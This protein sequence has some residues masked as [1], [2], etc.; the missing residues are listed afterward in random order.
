[1]ICANCKALR[2]VANELCAKYFSTT[3]KVGLS[4]LPSAITSRTIEDVTGPKGLPVI[5]TTLSLL[6]A[7]STPKL[8]YYID[9]RH[10]QYGPIFKESVGPVPCVFISDPKAMR[11]VFTHEGKY[12]IHILPEAWTTYNV[13]HNVSRGIFFM[14]GEEWLHFRRILNP[15]LLKGDQSWIDESC[16]PAIDNLIEKIKSQ[17][18]RYPYIDMEGLLYYWSLE[19]IVSILLGPQ[20]YIAAKQKLTDRID[21]LSSTLRLVFETSSKL[22]LISTKLAAKY[23]ISRWK[24]FEKSVTSALFSVADLVELLL[25][26]YVKNGEGLLG[27]LKAKMTTNEL[28]RIVTDLILAA[29]DTTAYSME[30]TLYLVGKNLEVQE[31][32]RKEVLEVKGKDD[33]G[34]KIYLKNAIKESLRL[35]PVAPFLTRILPDQAEICGYQMP[36]GTVLILSIFTA[37]RD[38]RNF[39]DPLHFDPDR[40]NRNDNNSNRMRLASIP[41]AIGARS[42]IGKKIAET[43]LQK[44]LAEIL[45]YFR[46]NVL[47]EEA[48]DVK[49]EMVAVPS[50]KIKFQFSIKQ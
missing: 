24:Q 5:G 20:N 28:V 16:K 47:N 12:P 17:S 11:A 2:S 1:M 13:L 26:D 44:T 46:V 8:H 29:G 15:I 45:V 3:F 49:L 39:Q 27:K 18:A 25:S 19:I 36:A 31:K 40:W 23:R 48:V 43:Q 32:L 4:S 35:Y 38:P 21:Y 33:L 34:S 30:W 50:E 22:M 10:Q 37:G 7:G 14:D 42:C 6:M 9:K 41:F